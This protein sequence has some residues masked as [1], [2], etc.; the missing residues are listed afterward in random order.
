MR[1]RLLRPPTPA[2]AA[3]P[4]SISRRHF[5]K[6][7]RR[8]GPRAANVFDLGLRDCQAA[9]YVRTCYAPRY[10]SILTKGV[11]QFPG[12]CRA[13]S[14]FLPARSD[15][16]RCGCVPKGS[17]HVHE[18]GGAV[19]MLGNNAVAA[20]GTVHPSHRP[21]SAHF[22]TR[23][24]GGRA[25]VVFEFL[26]PL[27]R[28]GNLRSAGAKQCDDLSYRPKRGPLMNARVEIDYAPAGQRC[29]ADR[30]LD[31][32]LGREG[33]CEDVT[34]CPLRWLWGLPSLPS[35]FVWAG[36]C[37]RSSWRRSASA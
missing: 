5:D 8:H 37:C 23:E 32:I 21:P 20:L 35:F 7:R 34:I 15:C 3:V 2:A 14:I 19:N 13:A 16:L 9:A 22:H 17:N 30:G 28:G 11:N 6:S 29:L 33:R 1:R 27:P 26:H 31:K 24:R 25:V 12:P 18:G 36:W 10:W 4:G